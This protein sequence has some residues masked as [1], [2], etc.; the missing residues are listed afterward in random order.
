VPAIAL[1]LTPWLID[2]DQHFAMYLANVVKAGMVMALAAMVVGRTP[3]VFI[4]KNQR[5]PGA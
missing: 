3:L 4:Q 2:F 1:G 5:G